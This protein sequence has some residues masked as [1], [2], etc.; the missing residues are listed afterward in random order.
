MMALYICMGV[1]NSDLLDN[2]YRRSQLLEKKKKRNANRT[3][4][5]LDGEP[6]GGFS[7]TVR[8]RLTPCADGAGTSLQ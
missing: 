7:P 4:A 6:G 5:K 1:P 8:A 3:R 2:L